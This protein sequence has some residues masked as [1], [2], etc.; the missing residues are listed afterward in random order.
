MY[1]TVNNKMKI[2]TS[3]MV[4]E[5]LWKRFRIFTIEKTGSARKISET[6]EKA[7]T[8]F[9]DVHKLDNKEVKTE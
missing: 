9:L 6:L 7:M 4:D 5:E 2:K 3:I 1:K 8:Q